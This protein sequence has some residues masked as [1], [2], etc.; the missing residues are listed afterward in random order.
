MN[1]KTT[2][3]A[4]KFSLNSRDDLSS[5]SQGKNDFVFSLKGRMTVY[6]VYQMTKG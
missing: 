1:R 2:I 3:R 5:V 6:L 4:Q